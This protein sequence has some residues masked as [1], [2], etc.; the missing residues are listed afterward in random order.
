MST[1]SVLSGSV[2]VPVPEPAGASLLALIAAALLARKRT[3]SS[4]K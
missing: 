2:S 1:D 3:N 4:H